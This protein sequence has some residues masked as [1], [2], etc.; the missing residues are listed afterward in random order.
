MQ[1]FYSYRHKHTEGNTADTLHEVVQVSWHANK[2]LYEA[3][4]LKV[5]IL[6]KVFNMIHI[7]IFI[8]MHLNNP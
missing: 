8:Y 6:L 5:T 4:K 1:G 3:G 2:Q 7:S